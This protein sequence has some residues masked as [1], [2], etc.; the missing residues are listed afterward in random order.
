MADS[1]IH[2]LIAQPI[3]NNLIVS[4]HTLLPVSMISLLRIASGKR[5]GCN[6]GNKSNFYAS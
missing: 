4:I 2:R 6:N 5:R 1:G 3:L